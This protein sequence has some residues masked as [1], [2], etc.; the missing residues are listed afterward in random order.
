MIFVI[1][2]E[3]QHVRRIVFRNQ[4]AGN[5]IVRHRIA[6]EQNHS[7]SEVDFVNTKCAGELAQNL[8][9]KLRT[10]I[11]SNGILQAIIKKSCRQLEQEITFQG[12]PNR[13]CVEFVA[14]DS[15]ND[16][17]SYFVVVLG[18]RF[19]IFWGR[20]ERFGATTLCSVFA[21][22]NLPPEFLLKCYRTNASDS[23]PLTKPEF[24]AL[25]TRS[26]SRMTRFS[27]R[28]GGCFFASMPSS[29]F[30]SLENQ[31]RAT[32]L[33]CVYTDPKYGGD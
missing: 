7:M 5:R 14:Q 28:F 21:V 1:S 12:L 22:V 10:V 4:R 25:R 30:V 2:Q 18:L 32:R 26:L 27:C 20:T 16:S 33:F 19:D 24:P 13:G 9:T 3:P 29:F 31:N 23:N 15:I 17:L 11:L 6:G 8:G